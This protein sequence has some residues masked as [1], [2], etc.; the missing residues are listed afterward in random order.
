MSEG[1]P[2]GPVVWADIGAG[3]LWHVL[4]LVALG[5]LVNGVGVL[6]NS[7]MAPFLAWTYGVGVVV[8]LGL[9]FARR[10][11]YIALGI[12]LVPVLVALAVGGCLLV[13]GPP[14]F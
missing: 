3:C 5:A 10:R 13:V 12:L 9:L 1:Q 4:A 14:R 7:W 8:A 11:P 6:M 2:R